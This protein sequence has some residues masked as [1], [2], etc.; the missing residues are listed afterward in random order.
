MPLSFIVSGICNRCDPK[1][2]IV[3]EAFIILFIT[4]F[5]ISIIYTVLTSQEMYPIPANCPP[6]YEYPS[7]TSYSICVLRLS[8]LICM[9]LFVL[10]GILCITANL[11]DIFPNEDDMN[12]LRKKNKNVPAIFRTTVSM[13]DIIIGREIIPK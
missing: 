10:F 4:W 5:I 8:N 7:Q 6:S 13:E 3:R 9:W 1:S 12:G 11:C 2:I